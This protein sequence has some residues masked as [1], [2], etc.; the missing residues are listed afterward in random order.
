M[1]YFVAPNAIIEK[2]VDIGDGSKIW[3]FSHVMEGAKIGKDCSIGSHCD[4]GRK[5]IIGN[6]VRIGDKVSIY[7]GT[8]LKD[9]VMISPGVTFMN[10]RKPRAY[11]KAK[12]Y[13]YIIVEEGATIESNAVI[14]GAVRI[15]KYSIIAA[16]ATVTKNIPDGYLA[17]GDPAYLKE[18]VRDYD[19]KA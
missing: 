16:G 11:R 18:K 13:E 8:I 2:D 17:V 14:K 1:N 15:G 9:K 3:Y 10:V 5:V 12:R 19:E 6:G 4:I 7:E